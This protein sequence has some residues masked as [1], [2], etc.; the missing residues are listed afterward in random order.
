MSVARPQLRG[1]LKSDLKRNF[2]IASV[3]SVISTVAW[4]VG[5]CDV[6]K[7]KY[8]D[9]YKTFD[10]DKE[11]ERLKAGGVLHSVNPDGSVGEGW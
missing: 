8:A 9:F 10:A 2:I 4:R 11:F 7:A 6:R 1:F 3:V 5:V